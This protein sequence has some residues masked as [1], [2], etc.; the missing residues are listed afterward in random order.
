MF[1]TISGNF[2]EFDASL[3]SK[4]IFEN[5]KIE[6]ELFHL[7]QLK[8]RKRCNIYWVLIFWYSSI[9]WNKF[10]ATSFVKV[11]ESEYELTEGV[12]NHGSIKTVKPAEFSGL[13][14]D[15]GKC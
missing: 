9:S 2:K 3:K 4:I 5:A 6:S 11:T 1:T 14:K 8:C 10:E 15:P 12:T 13:M 7:F